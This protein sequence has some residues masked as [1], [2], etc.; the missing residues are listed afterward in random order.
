[1]S[2]RD[3]MTAVG[4]LMFFLNPAWWLLSCIN[5]QLQLSQS[6]SSVCR[7]EEHVTVIYILEVC[8]FDTLL[9][10]SVWFPR[11]QDRKQRLNLL[12]LPLS[13]AIFHRALTF[14]RSSYETWKT[15]GPNDGS[16]DTDDSAW[17]GSTDPQG[18]PISGQSHRSTMR[19]RGLRRRPLHPAR[20]QQHPPGSTW[21]TSDHSADVWFLAL[22]VKLITRNLS[23]RLISTPRFFYSK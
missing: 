19:P 1:M 2:C 3:L 13:W 15:P 23:S 7:Q 16:T 6:V 17:L 4:D 10:S 20:Q 8:P 14:P 22:A 18:G 11:G 9:Y 5:L 12:H 21:H